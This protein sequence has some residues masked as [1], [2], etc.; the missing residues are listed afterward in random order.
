MGA[1]G[2]LRSD[3][4]TATCEV[5]EEV[6]ETRQVLCDFDDHIRDISHQLA[7]VDLRLEPG[8]WIFTGA[9]THVAVSTGDEVAVEIGALGRLEVKIE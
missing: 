4:L 5:N 1:F 3:S 6:R 7:L 8:D 2:S 9:Q